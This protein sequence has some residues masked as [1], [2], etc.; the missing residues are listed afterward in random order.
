MTETAPQIILGSASARRADLL[1]QISIRYRV[2]PAAIDERRHDGELPPAYVERVAL[3]KARASAERAAGEPAI[4]RLPVLGADTAVVHNGDTLGKPLDAADATA[5]LQRLSGDTH[6]VLTAVALVQGSRSDV[7]VVEAAVRF[8]KLDPNEIA[9]YLRSGE[10]TDKAGGYGIQGIGGIFAEH[11]A[12]SYSTIVGLPLLET[13]MLMRAFG[14][15][16]W[17]HRGT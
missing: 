2:L 14:V 10:G 3:A 16:T 13:E 12:G 7:R 8:R 6:S 1:D 5:M 15:A 4:A 11:I 17:Q 9:A